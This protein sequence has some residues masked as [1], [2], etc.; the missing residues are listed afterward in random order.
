[1]LTPY[2]FNRSLFIGGGV[3]LQKWGRIPHAGS[4]TPGQ[5]P[6]IQ[7]N[8]LGSPRQ[9]SDWAGGSERW[10]PGSSSTGIL[11][12]ITPAMEKAQTISR[13]EA[14]WVTRPGGRGPLCLVAFEEKPKRKATSEKIQHVYAGWTP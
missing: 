14:A 5:D 13:R 8:Q 7:N 2:E 11:R 9:A 12:P 6:P 4:G 1:M 10:I 3:P